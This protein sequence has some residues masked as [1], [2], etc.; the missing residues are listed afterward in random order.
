MVP[1][2]KLLNNAREEKWMENPGE[3]QKRVLQNIVQ[4]NQN[5]LFGREYLFRQIQNADDFST[6]VPLSVY[7]DFEPYI[8]SMIS[9][10][11]NVLV[12]EPF[13]AWVET[14]AVEG[15]RLLPYTNSMARGIQ[16]AFLRL[17][18]TDGMEWRYFSGKVMAGLE[19][20]YT[21]IVGGKPV[22]SLSSLHAR[23]LREIPHL[24][25][26]FTPSPDTA[27]IPDVKR[28][29]MEIATQV[30][31]QDIV[32]AVTDPVLFL[33]FLRKM[34]T[35]YNQVLPIP[36]V[37]ELWPNFS[38][39]ISDVRLNPYKKVFK[40]VLGD[41]EFRELFCPED[42]TVAIQ[43][44]EKGYVPLYDQNFLEFIPVHQWKTM[45]REGGTYREFEFDCMTVNTVQPGREYVLV[46]TTPGGLYR[47]ITGDV[48][49]IVDELHIEWSG[50]VDWKMSNV[51]GAQEMV[52]LREIVRDELQMP[53]GT[54]NQVV[55][56][57]SEPMR[58]LF[59]F[60]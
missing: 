45:E 60:I 30:L 32:C 36:D 18:A 4:K 19:V 2:L 52:L 8:R 1:V 20:L 29:W 17:F 9:G 42:L 57:E 34:N 7:E 44:D 14:F 31:R 15:T 28:R 6:Y 27:L 54:G 46:I 13:S 37:G 12:T 56:V 22:G 38:L 50:C 58:S 5:T 16:K 24:R 26:A 53:V 3:I 40:S 55:A 51:L 41:V 23:T 21:D 39:I 11:E 25:T 35:E 59:G 48:V 47:Y 43:I 49:K 33:L 10:R